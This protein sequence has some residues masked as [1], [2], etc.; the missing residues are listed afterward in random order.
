MVFY[1]K[2]LAKA[3]VQVTFDK[4]WPDPKPNK[5]RITLSSKPLTSGV[6]A[7]SFRSVLNIPR[8]VK[9]IREEPDLP[10]LVVN[11]VRAKFELHRDKDG[12]LIFIIGELLQ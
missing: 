7:E 2:N 3:P 4:I 11:T 5:W 12:D 1:V 8:P 6:H 10:I 9:C